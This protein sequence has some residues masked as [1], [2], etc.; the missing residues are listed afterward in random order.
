MNMTQTAI[1]RGVTFAM[2]YLIAVGF[3]LFS[4]LRLNLD[5]Y[6][7]MNFPYISVITQYTGVGPYDVE[8]VLTRPIEETVAS[9]KNVKKVTS[10]SRQGLSVTM[11]EF[12]WG[13]DMDQAETDVRRNLDFVRDYLPPDASEPLVFKFDPSM[14]PILYLA[15]S[16]TIHG[17][18]ELRRISEEY[19]EPRIERIPGVASVYTSGGLKREIKVIADPLAMKAHNIAIQQIQAA[20]QGA[21]LQ[22]PSGYIENDREEF[23]IETAGQFTSLEQIANT[24]VAVYNGSI[25]RIRDVASVQDGFADLRQEVWNNG[26][27]ATF[28]FIQKS[29]D[30]NTVNVCRS[31]RNQLPRIEQELPRGVNVEVAIDLSDFIVNSMSNLSSTAWQAVL[32]TFLVLLF[33]LRNLRSSIIVAVSIPVSVI[34]TFA[35]MDQAGITLNIISMAGL[36]LAIGMLVDNSIVVLENIFRH[37][38]ELKENLVESADKGAREVSMAITASTLTTLVVFLPVLFV[39]GLAGQ[40]FRDM[41]VTICFSLT[42]SL[43]VALTLIPLLASRFLRISRSLKEN[44]LAMRSKNRIAGWLDR[45][46][47][48]YRVFL[49]WA[50]ERRK[51]VLFTTALLFIV[52]AV[53]LFL[54]GGEFFP[55]SDVGYMS[56]TIERSP[57]TSMEA[58]EKSMRQLTDIIIKDVPEADN[59]YGNFGQG[60]GVM[61]LFSSRS[62][63]QGDMTLRLKPRSQRDRN[64]FAIQDALRTQLSRI[65]DMEVKF[66][67]RGEAM[68]SQADI[69][70]NIFG[71]DLKVSEGIANEVIKRLKEVKGVAEFSTNIDKPSP[72][73]KI[74]LDRQRIADLGLSAAQVGNTVSTCVLGAVVTRYRDQGDEYDI[75]LQL[76]KSNRNSKEDLEN[77]LVMTPTGKQIPLRAISTIDYDKTPQEINREDQERI[78]TINISIAGRDLQSVTNDV[79]AIIASVP[80]P[81]DYRI[82]IS[83]AAQDMIES[84]MYLGI[85]FMVAMLLTYMV[86]ASQ[87][88]SLVDPFIIMFTIP[89]SVIGV[90][91]ALH[92]TGTDMNVMALI[93]IVMLVGI[94]VN[95]GIVLV[96]VINHFRSQGMELFDAIREGGRVRLRPVLMTA[97]TTVAGMLPLALGLGDSGETW[98]PMARAVMGGLTVATVLTL[99]IVPIIYSYME[100]LSA[101]LK[102]KRKQ[103]EAKRLAKGKIVEQF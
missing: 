25:I 31:I 14:Q 33:F 10:A 103:R 94:V 18:A 80:T 7:E 16:S 35:V 46:Y 73:L 52:S 48:V 92:L 49:D 4:L 55:K 101:W 97:L 67:D 44:G 102:K 1:K 79:R 82:E 86:M 61:A 87:F 21:N 29:S 99:V 75:R 76:D 2:I 3:G 85:A 50:L 26:K 62:S 13:T 71:H 96:D 93:G 27:P 47:A 63:A 60:E 68:F 84:F 43:I 15:V 36:A 83:G 23:S 56:L 38:D 22:I 98:A 40:L 78:V 89:L 88:E 69:V 34:V 20:L 77:L 51:T 45:L 17:Q 41:V 58:M 39:P 81:G 32:L 95:N 54:T 9:V 90:A 70:L 59:I 66:Q 28:V 74:N 8:T 11:L 24:S 6:P 53:S 5:L 30:A 72:E 64:M 12:N 37:H 91:V 100:Q 19:L 65:P 42:I 57:G